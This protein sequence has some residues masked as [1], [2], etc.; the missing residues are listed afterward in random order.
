MKQKTLN[1]IEESISSAGRW[2]WIELSNDSVQLEFE[3]VQLYKPSMEKYDNHSSEIAIRLAD[4]AFFSIFYNDDNDIDF[5]DSK[6]DFSYKISDDG[7]KFQDFG[8]F[9]EINNEYIHKKVVLGNLPIDL[10]NVE[11]DF[12]LII[13]FEKIAIACGANQLNFFN[14][15]ES[16][17]DE[18]IKKLSNQWWIYWVDYWKSKGNDNSYEY[19]P[20]CEAI[21]FNKND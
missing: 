10:N 9:N 3:D 5:I 1:L 17:N 7:L 8:L 21:P 11:F 15:F 16:L 6:R 13:I 12:L 14:D 20:A 4:N 18:D 2:T 19:D